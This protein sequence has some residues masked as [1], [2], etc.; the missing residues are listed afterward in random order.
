MDDYLYLEEIDRLPLAHRP[1]R[2]NFEFMEM[3]NY[4]GF[5]KKSSH[6][7]YIFGSDPWSEPNKSACPSLPD[8]LPETELLNSAANHH[9]CSA[10]RFL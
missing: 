1:K 2:T 10:G 4:N 5:I 6:K 3:S 7:K 8:Y 9:H